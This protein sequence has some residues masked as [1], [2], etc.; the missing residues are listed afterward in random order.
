MAIA[1]L[2]G[3]SSAV[4]WTWYINAIATHKPFQAAAADLSTLI[5]S[6]LCLGWVIKEK[7]LEWWTT[8]ITASI[9]TGIMV[10]LQS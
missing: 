2:V 7:Y 5:I 9:A 3:M 1:V 4:I 10:Y 6:R 8:A